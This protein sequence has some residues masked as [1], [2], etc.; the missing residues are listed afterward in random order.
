LTLII[1]FFIII[2]RSFGVMAI[3]AFSWGGGGEGVRKLSKG[4]YRGVELFLRTKNTV[5]H[6]KLT[7]YK[8]YDR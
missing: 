8:N 4:T 1:C 6:L 5:E 7:V 3:L 2:L